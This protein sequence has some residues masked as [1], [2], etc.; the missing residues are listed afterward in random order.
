MPL[1][2]G[3][4]LPMLPGVPG[5]EKGAAGGRPIPSGLRSAGLRGPVEKPL[6][7][8]LVRRLES[9]NGDGALSWL[10]GLV[11]LAIGDRP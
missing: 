6:L 3:P 1:G 10:F 8:A 2:P 11:L 4:A 9:S 5:A 7:L